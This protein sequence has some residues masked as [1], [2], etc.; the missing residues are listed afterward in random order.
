MIRPLGLAILFVGALAGFLS[1]ALA[2]DEPVA[3]D[4]SARRVDAERERSAED[5]DERVIAKKEDQL[6]QLRAQLQR[7]VAAD[8]S[9]ASR[10]RLEREIDR[11][12]REVE[13]L[14]EAHERRRYREHNRKREEPAE[15]RL[16]IGLEGVHLLHESAERFDRAGMPEVA[17]DL[18]HRAEELEREIHHRAERFE[19]EAREAEVRETEARANE[20]REAEERAVQERVNAERSFAERDRAFEGQLQ[21]MREQ[22]R[23]LQLE[24][25]RLRDQIQEK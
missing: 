19:A 3:G 5:A 9:D 16:H 11:N 2:V 8:T 17:R 12:A 15:A 21:D 13:M 22:V 4:T 20:R 7:L 10:E 1:A 25:E 23:R 18:R 6:R 24:V 14:V